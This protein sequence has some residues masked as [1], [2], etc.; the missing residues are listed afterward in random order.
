[1]NLNLNKEKAK[2]VF[3]VIVYVI[4]LKEDAIY[5]I[6][7]PLQPLQWNVVLFELSSTT[8]RRKRRE[9]ITDAKK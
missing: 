5:F 8:M 7:K 9:D 2:L 4:N 1:M 3:D 6:K